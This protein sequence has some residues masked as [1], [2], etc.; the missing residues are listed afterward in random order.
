[1]T[2]LTGHIKYK[3]GIVVALIPKKKRTLLYSFRSIDCL[4]KTMTSR[5]AAE[6]LRPCSKKALKDFLEFLSSWQCHAAGVGG[7]LG[8]STAGGLRVT[9]SST[10]SRF[11]YLVSKEFKYVMTSRLSQDLLENLLV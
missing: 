2:L 7:F 4:I 5:F 1:M 3:N 9:I 10:L 6:A 8:D 11:D